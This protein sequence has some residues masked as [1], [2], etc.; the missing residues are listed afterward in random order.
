MKSSR[1]SQSL[2]GVLSVA[3]VWLL[4]TATALAITKD[5]FKEK[6]RKGMSQAEVEAAVGKPDL[7]TG[8]PPFVVWRYRGV[9]DTESKIKVAAAVGLRNEV[10]ERVLFLTDEY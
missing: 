1:W 6:V 2:C 5:E 4:A 10:V 9:L 7:I 8:R 3:M